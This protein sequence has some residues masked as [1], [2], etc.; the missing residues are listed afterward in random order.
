MAFVAGAT[1][2]ALV[3]VMG[4]T[5][6]TL[7][8]TRMLAPADLWGVVT[9]FSAED[10]AHLIL[11][12]TRIP[13]TIL[14]VLAGAA[15]GAAGVVMQSLTRNPLAEPGILGVNAGSALAVAVA[16]A[17]FGVIQPAGYFVF[18]LGG[19]AVAGVLVLLL[20]GVR[21]GSD[22]V[23]LVLAGAA[24][25]VVLGAL[26][27]IVIVNADDL[28][29]DRYRNWIVGSLQGRGLDVLIPTLVLVGAGVILAL[30]LARS[31]DTVSLGG[32]ASRALGARPA[33]V[34][35]LAGTA[36]VLLSAGATAAAGPIAFIGLTSPH[37]ARRWVGSDHRRMLP[38]AMLLGAGLVLVADVAGRVVA[39]P[40][41]VGVGIMAALIG[42]PVFVAIV[43]HRRM[44]LL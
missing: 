12:H 44:A 27:Q 41:E 21:R 15:L 13:R 5:L 31:L 20:G 32:D 8:G 40:G 28:L 37:V 42:G 36:V 7:V 26:A 25:S 33:R 18:A 14:A 11:L 9:R 19:A 38:A 10:D 30:S 35:T 29:F 22:P 17:V 34:W 6:S 1:L 39:L 2:L 23:R 3:V 4:M 16:I 24:L 43:R